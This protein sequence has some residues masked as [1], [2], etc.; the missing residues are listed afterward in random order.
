MA[1]APSGLMASSSMVRALTGARVRG[2]G[3][4]DTLEH[5]ARGRLRDIEGGAWWAYPL[6]A[7]DVLQPRGPFRGSEP[8]TSTRVA[9]LVAFC[10]QG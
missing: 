2:V 7:A 3:E 10:G 6:P 9:W 1:N 4:T 8:T 5:Q